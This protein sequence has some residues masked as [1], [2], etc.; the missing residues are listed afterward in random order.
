METEPEP[1]PCEDLAARGVKEAFLE[2]LLR[3]LSLA[4]WNLLVFFAGFLASGFLSIE[5]LFSVLST[6]PWDFAFLFVLGFVWSP[7]SLAERSATPWARGWGR[8]LG[9]ACCLALLAALGLIAA[10]GQFSYTHG[11]LR[12]G[13][14]EAGL[15]A[16]WDLLSQALAS[17]AET[18]ALLLAFAPPF[19]F[20]ALT[21]LRRLHLGAQVTLTLVASFL[22]SKLALHD[23]EG[24]PQVSWLVRNPWCSAWVG[25]FLLLQPIS[26]S[27]ALPL[28]AAGV[29]RL[30]PGAK[31]EPPCPAPPLAV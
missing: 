7:L 15:D 30:G 29:E 21:K 20:A 4:V 22:L 19:A 13:G 8:Q 5:G 28:L 9:V 1:A 26:L 12:G 24:L 23:F 2:A 25:T 18:R 11:F 27:V 16:A 31:T 17:S 6:Q 10:F 3:G 14:L